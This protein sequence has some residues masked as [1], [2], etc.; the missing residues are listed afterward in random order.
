MLCLTGEFVDTFQFANF[1]R[2]NPSKQVPFARAIQSL[3]VFS[4]GKLADWICLAEGRAIKQGIS[5]MN[6]FKKLLGAAALA[7]LSFSFAAQAQTATYPVVAEAI[8]LRQAINNNTQ[9]GQN[10]G[11]N[12]T[13]IAT[14]LPRM[15]ACQPVYTIAKNAMDAEIAYVAGGGTDVTI[16]NNY[17]SQVNSALAGGDACAGITTR[18]PAESFNANGIKYTNIGWPSN[19]FV[20]A[21][22]TTTNN[23][24]P[25]LRARHVAAFNAGWKFYIFRSPDD[26]KNST[27]YTTL[28]V[29]T[30]EYNALKIRGAFALTNV[31]K[32]Q[33]FFEKFYDPNGGLTGSFVN[34]HPTA[35]IV[36]ETEHVNDR[37]IGSLLS[38]AKPDVSNSDAGFIKAYNL[39]KARVLAA[40]NVNPALKEN[41]VTNP[42]G[43]SE[44]FAELATYW[45][46]GH[47]A[48]SGVSAQMAGTLYSAADV[49]FYFSEA[50]TYMVGKKKSNT[51]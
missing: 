46:T 21:V 40:S 42:N 41:F 3:S 28:G 18:T 48:V 2:C 25:N 38:P 5:E 31:E 36:H 47:W 14:Y 49:L 34:Y 30:A 7:S 39:G 20:N 44:L 37:R 51:W 43:K 16:R 45:D 35:T 19:T 22:I 27:L 6:I 1:I 23:F 4:A 24:P 17:I 15:Y 10:L 12:N 8:S 50:Q 33:V 32:T 26:F 29:T 11:N 13:T 9:A